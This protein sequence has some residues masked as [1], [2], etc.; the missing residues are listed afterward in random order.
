MITEACPVIFDLLHMASR[1][2]FAVMEPVS[3][4]GLKCKAHFSP[5]APGHRLRSAALQALPSAPSAHSA[6][7]FAAVMHHRKNRDD[8][9]TGTH[10]SLDQSCHHRILLQFFPDCLP[11]TL[12]RPGQRIRQALDQ[13]LRLRHLADL[14][15]VLFLLSGIL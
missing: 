4:T 12:L 15:L 3:S 13:C 14:K 10:I 5:S 8:R 9:L 2:C 6:Y 7:P 1:F 11:D